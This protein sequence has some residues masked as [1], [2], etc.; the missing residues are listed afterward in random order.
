MTNEWKICLD[1]NTTNYLKSPSIHRLITDIKAESQYIQ[2]II[3]DYYDNEKMIKTKE[4]ND[5]FNIDNLLELCDLHFYREEY[6]IVIA[7]ME[8]NIRRMIQCLKKRTISNFPSQ[9]ANM[10]ITYIMTMF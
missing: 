9:K 1:K 5:I 10:I 3:N 6:F 2:T 4:C 8:K 7:D